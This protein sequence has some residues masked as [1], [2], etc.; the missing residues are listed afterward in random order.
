MEIILILLC[1]FGITFFLQHKTYPLL[2]KIKFFKEMLE[3]TFCTAVHAGWMSYLLCDWVNF[4]E[5]PFTSMLTN[6]MVYAFAGG[7]FTYALDAVAS[8]W[9]RE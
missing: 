5:L 2:S 9:E 8:Y 4:I 1:A 6:L 3:C 7:A